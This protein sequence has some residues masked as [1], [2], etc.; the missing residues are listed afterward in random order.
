MSHCTI[1]TELHVLSNLSP[2][3]E[4]LATNVTFLNPSLKDLSHKGPETPDAE[5][6][7]S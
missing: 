2:E 5:P 6:K 1:C 7:P 3:T 4:K